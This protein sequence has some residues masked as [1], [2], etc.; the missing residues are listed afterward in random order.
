RRVGVFSD[1]VRT[2]PLTPEWL[3]ALRGG[4]REHGWIEGRNMAID[5]RESRTVEERLETVA[6]L[7]RAKPEVIVTSGIGVGIIHP[8]VSP[9][10]PGWAPVRDIPIVFAGQ[11]DPVRIGLV[12]SLRRPGGSVT[13]LSYL[14]VELNSKRLQ[15]LRELLPTLSR[16]GVL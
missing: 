3:E 1:A 4:L 6:S 12:E 8:T 9:R 5:F 2:G 7:L 13:G 10:P 11:S 16:V 15:I 14:G